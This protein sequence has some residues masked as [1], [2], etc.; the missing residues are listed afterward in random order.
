MSIP[1]YTL[2]FPPDGSSLG[3]TKVQIRD[4][5]DGTFETLGI[6]H[7]N[8]N[9][10]PGDN[11]AGYHNLIHMV[12]Q[13]A[14]PSAITGITQIFAGNPSV[15]INPNTGKP[16]GIPSGADN[17]LFL[18]TGG[19]SFCQMTGRSR[20]QNGY[21]WCGGLLIQWGTAT[22]I[23]T[24]SGNTLTTIDFP[25]IYPNQIFAVIPSALLSGPPGGVWSVGVS[26][27]SLSGFTAVTRGSSALDAV[28]WVSIG[29]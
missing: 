19:N 14:T 17:Q 11:P 23:V 5:L 8:N 9:G 26:S 25:E 12:A 3:Q 2:G 4:N 21:V 13:T 27:P 28:S 7:I 15:L 18:L 16:N 20:N 10:L 6:D 22:G 29:Y 1:E 24:G